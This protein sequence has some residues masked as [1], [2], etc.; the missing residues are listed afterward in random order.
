M[1]SK[2]IEDEIVAEFKEVDTNQSGSLSM[3]E[4][5]TVFIKLGDSPEDADVQVQVSKSLV[6][7]MMSGEATWSTSESITGHKKHGKGSVSQHQ[8]QFYADPW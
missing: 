5:K 7:W 2:Y 6:P 1:S 8:T 3:D 4:L